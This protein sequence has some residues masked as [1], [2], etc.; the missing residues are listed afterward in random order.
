M[1]VS[2]IRR[3]MLTVALA[4]SA[5]N[6]PNSR[7]NTHASR[8]ALVSMGSTADFKNGLTLEDENSVWKITSFLHVPRARGRALIL[9]V[10]QLVTQL[11]ETTASGLGS[12][13]QSVGALQPARSRCQHTV[14]PPTR[15][16]VED[17]L[18]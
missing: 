7:L 4:H 16:K 10:P 6:P 9:L 5:F 13:T 17:S 14:L 3:R 1:R 18:P 11:P 12:P 8:S 2:G 15:V